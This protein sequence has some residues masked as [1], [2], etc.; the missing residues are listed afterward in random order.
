MT[1]VFIQYPARPAPFCEDEF[2]TLIN[3]LHR[4]RKELDSL[5]R[6]IMWMIPGDRKTRF[7]PSSYF[8]TAIALSHI[9]DRHFYKVP[10]YPEKSKFTIPIPEIVR[11]IRLAYLQPAEPMVGHC[12]Q[13]ILPAGMVIGRNHDGR[14]CRHIKVVSDL[15]G[16]IRTAYPVCDI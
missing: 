8:L 7:F 12:R 6:R 16:F 11:L 5:S 4:S 13:R 3:T 1:A 2:I 9:L 10:R 14:P 15:Y